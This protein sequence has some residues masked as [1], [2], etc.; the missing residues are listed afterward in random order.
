MTHY[1]DSYYLVFS[2]KIKESESVQRNQDCLITSMNDQILESNCRF[3][4]KNSELIRLTEELSE[5]TSNWAEE[6]TAMQVEQK[7]YEIEISHLTS[8]VENLQTDHRAQYHQM[9]E[10]DNL[11]NQSTNQM[12]SLQGEVNSVRFSNEEVAMQLQIKTEMIEKLNAEISKS[13]DEV[14]VRSNELHQMKFHFDS[15]QNQ[16]QTETGKIEQCKLSV[17]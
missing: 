10:K 5:K 9:M 14:A 7:R 3:D 1:Y 16:L 13:R 15:L 8:V 17:I 2:K 12:R 6:R 4:S 11:L